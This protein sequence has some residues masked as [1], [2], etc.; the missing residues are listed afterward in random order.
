[1][2]YVLYQ[3]DGLSVTIVSTYRVRSHAENERDYLR[4]CGIRAWVEE[5]E[6][7]I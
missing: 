5:C 7:K 2:K 6:V 3:H 1:M 4:A